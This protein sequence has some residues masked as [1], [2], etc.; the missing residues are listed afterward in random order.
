LRGREKNDDPPRGEG[1]KEEERNSFKGGRD[2]KIENSLLPMWEK[3]K[4]GRFECKLK[5]SPGS[6]GEGE[7]DG[8]KKGK[9]RV[10]KFNS[11]QKM[12]EKREKK[13]GR[14]AS[15]GV[16]RRLVTLSIS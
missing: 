13:G 10:S 2:R 3:K 7:A 8:Y 4:R 1:K 12:K 14:A 6:R 5:G 11:L 16:Q 9:G 15:A